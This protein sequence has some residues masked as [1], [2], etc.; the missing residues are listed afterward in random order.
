MTVTTTYAPVTATGNGSTTEFAFPYLVYQASHLSITLDGVSTSAWTAATYG[1]QSGVTVTFTTAP[2]SGVAIVIER[3]VPYTQETDLENFDGNPADVTEKQFDLLA[4]ADQQIAE[5][6]GRAIVVPVGTS[7]TSNEI[8]GTISAT[9]QLIALTTSGPS[10]VLLSALPSVDFDTVFTSLASGDLIQYD[11]ANWVNKDIS[12][13]IV[14]SLDIA[15][16]SSAAA[17]ISLAEDT[18][19]GTNKVVFQAPASLAADYTLTLPADDGSADQVL[20]TDGSGNLS[21]TDLNSPQN[22]LTGLTLSNDTDADHDINVTAGQA[23]NSTNASTLTLASEITK[24]I[25]AS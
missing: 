5:E 6:Q 14:G 21:W 15:G 12:E 2:A 20:Q 11:G 18:D 4:M 9:T 13:I 16:T 22:Y 19:N 17:S 3:I 7:L 8:S 23:S 25:D 24:Q 10:V 1:Q